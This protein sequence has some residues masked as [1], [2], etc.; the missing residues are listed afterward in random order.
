MPQRSTG[1]HR[2]HPV[3]EHGDRLLDL[4]LTMDLSGAN[5]VEWLLEVRRLEVVSCLAWQLNYSTQHAQSV[6]ESVVTRLT[7]IDPP[8]DGR[9]YTHS[10]SIV[11]AAMPTTEKSD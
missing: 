7:L 5:S 2:Q 11:T 1:R 4:V 8:E 9:S 10:P 3:R 6:V